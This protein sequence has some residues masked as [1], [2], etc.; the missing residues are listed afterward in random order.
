MKK[1]KLLILSLMTCLFLTISC[2]NNNETPEQKQKSE[3]A[4]G[5]VRCQCIGWTDT[6]KDGK[7]DTTRNND[8]SSKCQ[9]PEVDH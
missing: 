3:N 2:Q 5:C 9:H 1:P 7:C 8:S 6:N 4:G